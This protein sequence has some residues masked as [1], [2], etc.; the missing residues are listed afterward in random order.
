M[1]KLFAQLLLSCLVIWPLWGKCQS[2]TETYK[3]AED[4]LEDEN[5]HQALIQYQGLLSES[6]NNAN[7]NFKIGYCYLLT[8]TE[9]NKAV[10]YLE[11]AVNRISDNY[12]AT[13]PNEQNAPIEAYFYLGKAYHVNY[14]FDDA[15]RV[16]FQLK[17]LISK[18]DAEFSERIDREL[19]TCQVA[20]QL[21]KNPVDM[22]VT[23]LGSNV[24]SLFTEHSPVI[25]GDESMLI[26][27]SKRKG[28]TG[29]KQTDDGQFFED[30]YISTLVGNNYNEAKPISAKINTGGHEASIGLS[31][32]G[33]KLLIYRDDMGDGNIYISERE[34]SDWKTPEKLPEVI[35]SKARETHA[36]FSVDQNEIYFTS[37]RKG[38]FGGLDIY[39]VRRLPN[40]KW[41]KAQ[42]LGS[43]INTPYDE[44]GPYLHPDGQ[45]LFFAS[46]GHNTMGGYDV[47]VS[48]IDENDKWSTPENLGYPINTPDD[49][50]Y[51]IPSVDGRRAYYA[52]FANNSI[53][54]YDLFRI[55]L[56]EAHV[57]NQVVIAGM[58]TTRDG[59]RLNNALVTIADTDDNIVGIY[60]P[61]PEVGKFLLILPRGKRF[62]AIIESSNYRKLVY[63][64]Q[65]PADSYN[66]T[67][68]VV[69]FN[70]III[71]PKL[72]Q[73]ETKSALNNVDA[74]TLEQTRVAMNANSDQLFLANQGKS[75][76][77]ESAGNIDTASQNNNVELAVVNYEADTTAT[78]DASQ[79]AVSGSEN[80]NT[81][82]AAT[83]WLKI[84]DKFKSKQAMGLLALLFVV[85]VGAIAI[86]VGKKVQGNRN[87]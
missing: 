34:G 74:K 76:S 32:D 48:Y 36:T 51:Y 27:T 57:R 69:Q 79:A 61:D 43:T 63:E 52:S 54:S 45:S 25:S 85:L 20:R 22:T 67:G 75:G 18:D 82:Q 56:S 37:D 42:N 21:I 23:N 40:G 16:F 84:K 8:A 14:R 30:I 11:F 2:F 13:N 35:N 72:A 49:N 60:T 73:G 31:F 46:K 81:T 41:S 50:I 70:D 26:F 4:L 38:G 5:Y 66:Q 47:F 64:I 44:E 10:P 71:S 12:N 65:I 59:I 6:P 86:Y 1:P 24:N 68:R 7:L 55:D 28:N 15:E 77:I 83:K 39:R 9:K 33:S 62:T 19:K 87:R 3:Q 53:G 78:L 80:N 29:D 17:K 58:A